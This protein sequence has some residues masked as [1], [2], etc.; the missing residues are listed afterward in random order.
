M[1]NFGCSDQMYY[2]NFI[3]DWESLSI[4]T[5]FAPGFANTGHS[6]NFFFQCFE[7]VF[8]AEILWH[9]DP[10]LGGDHKQVPTTNNRHATTEKLLEVVFSMICAVVI[11]TQHRSTHVSTATVEVQQ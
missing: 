10:L 7:A 11:A 9:T 2:A 3:K 8:N 4:H 5:Q 6:V 1:L